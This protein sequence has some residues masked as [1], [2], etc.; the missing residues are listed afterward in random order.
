MQGTNSFD[1]T[2]Y[3]CKNKTASY[4]MAPSRMGTK[5]NTTAGLFDTEPWWALKQWNI[6]A[7]PTGDRESQ[8]SVFNSRRLTAS[9][10]NLQK[11]NKSKTCVSVILHRK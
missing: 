11:M 3:V 6:C 2:N 5:G 4:R 7:G 9:T 8:I 1:R 10:N